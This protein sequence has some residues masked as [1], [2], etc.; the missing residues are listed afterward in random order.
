MAQSVSEFIIDRLIQ[1]GL[2]HWYGYHGDGIGGFDGAMGR[3]QR[4]GK[5]FT[6]IRP[7]HGQVAAFM[8]T[9][10]AKFPQGSGVCVA[11]S[12]PGAIHLLNRLYDAKGDSTPVVAIVGQ[13][14]RVSLS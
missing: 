11:T 14:A 5:H 6:Y 3:A 9:A 10:N 12:G 8:A 13:Q 1:W 2:H 4:A 7:S